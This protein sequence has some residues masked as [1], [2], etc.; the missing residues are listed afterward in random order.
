MPKKKNLDLAAEMGED[1]DV[2][3]DE[4]M[5]AATIMA[6]APVPAPSAPVAQPITMSVAD[7]QAI[8]QTAVQ[9]AQ[10]GNQAI[11]EIVTQGIAQARKPIPEGT[12]QSNPRISDANPLGDRDHPRPLLKCDFFLGTQDVDGKIAR[13]YPYEQGDLTVREILALNILEP[14]HYQIHLHDDTQIKVSVVPELDGATDALRRL[15][16]VVPTFVTEKKSAHRNMLPG[17]CNIVAQ[18]TGHDFSK[19]KGEEL[20]WFMAEHRAKRYVSTR[21]PVAA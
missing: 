1:V 14:G 18:I 8:V 12:D 11:A 17:P 20:A 13:T 16:L 2:T 19:L 5:D 21:E 6:P 9:A 7:I 10:S 4:A 15:V 3:E